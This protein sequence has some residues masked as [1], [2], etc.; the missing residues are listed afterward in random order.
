MKYIINIIIIII[1]IIII[2]YPLVTGLFF[3][4]FLLNQR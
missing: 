3:L 4:K 1:I 2:L